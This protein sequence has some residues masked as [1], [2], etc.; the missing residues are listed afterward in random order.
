MRSLS[1]QPSS[2]AIP[3]PLETPVA[4]TRCWSTQCVASTA[5]SRSDTKRTSSGS[6]GAASMFQ[7]GRPEKCDD[8]SASGYTAMNP[9]ASASVEKPV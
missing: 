3:P 1:A 4:N 9:W 6:V 7:N 2:A 8:G 5:V